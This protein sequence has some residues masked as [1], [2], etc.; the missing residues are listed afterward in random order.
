M[1]GT[2]CASSHR[3]LGRQAGMT[4][5]EV[6]VAMTVGIILLLAMGTL[7]ANSTRV[8]KANDDFSRMQENGAYALNAI[9]ADLRQ[10]AFYGHIASNDVSVLTATVIGRDYGVCNTETAW[11]T[12][13]GQP[14]FGFIEGVT[15]TAADAS[16]P[17]ITAANLILTALPDRPSPIL[18]VRGASGVRV[19]PAAL[20]AT[21]LYVQSDPGGGIFFL[22]SEYEKLAASRKRTIAGGAEAPIYPYQAKAYYLRPCSRPTGNG[23]FVCQASDDDGQPI[24]TLVRQELAG[25]I[26][27]ERTV[28]EGIEA[29]RILYGV[30]TDARG[31]P[32]AY[33]ETPT[34]DQFGQVVAVRVSLLVRS[35]R[36]TNGYDDSSRSYDLDGDGVAE[37]N[38]AADGL[39]CNYHRHVFTQ[40]FQVRNIAQRLESSPTLVSSP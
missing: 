13:F 16:M 17:C 37:L 38:C 8:F 21:T 27:G 20:D 31:T 1:S 19:L 35:P 26:F 28:A 2:W 40:T 14:L 23:G 12:N 4:L 5:V 39:P 7:F 33:T 24:P 15:T 9:G 34:A 36:L 32:D 11:A 3:V 6:M 30:D 10:A 25:T 22:G 18:V 29:M